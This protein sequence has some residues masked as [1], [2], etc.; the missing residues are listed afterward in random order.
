MFTRESEGG[1]HRLAKA[2]Q[3]SALPTAGFLFVLAVLLPW[4]SWQAGDGTASRSSGLVDL[5]GIPDSV[6]QR[7]AVVAVSVDPAQLEEIFA[8]PYQRGRNWERV[9]SVAFLSDGEVQF[10]SVA[11]IRV[12]GGG[13]R[14]W[15]PKSLRLF[16][17]PSL[18]AEPAPGDVL[19]LDPTAEYR[20]LVLHNDR[21]F[22][23][24][25]ASWHYA[26]PLAYEITERL[27]VP[28]VKALPATLVVNDD[29]PLPFV[30][31]ES[32]TMD[33]LEHRF[34]HREF[35]VL[36]TKDVT[37]L[38]AIRTQG[39][40][41]ML[42]ARFGEPDTW[43]LED[44]ASLVDLDNLSRWFLAVLFCG[45]RDEF[46]G[47]MVLD[48][49]RPD[50]K[51]F[52]VAWDMDLSFARKH[53]GDAP[54]WRYDTFRYWMESDDGNPDARLFL[55]RHL[56]TT[57]EEFRDAFARLFE[58]ARRELVTPEFIEE[59]LSRY[60]RLATMHGVS[61]LRYQPKVRDFLTNRAAGLE[62]ILRSRDILEDH[63]Q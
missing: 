16:F 2:P 28:T 52:W 27:G 44:I 7:P 10:E 39:P 18:Q 12:H 40:L 57:S 34:G 49:S 48:Q 41:A 45:T 13:S 15:F 25:S 58:T 17:R 32:L 47:K 35:L 43:S 62:E 11:G 33:W 50:G 1:R 38:D 37:V 51:W 63:S 30:I 8:F 6:L 36:E 54:S 46:Q 9:G 29:P 53:V 21:R 31:A 26:N 22:G 23:F 5:S 3:A 55:L 56:F 61:D 42:R 14:Q 20:S 59:A 19:G 4:L 24:D 60:E